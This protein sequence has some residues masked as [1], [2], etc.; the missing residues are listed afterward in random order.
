[1]VEGR[2]VFKGGEWWREYEWWREGGDGVRRVVE[3][4]VV[5]K[6]SG[7]WKG[8]G[9]GMR[10]VEGRKDGGRSGEELK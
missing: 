9:G 4:G 3:G 6:G 10:V 5:E 2:G 8:S 1:M 7:G